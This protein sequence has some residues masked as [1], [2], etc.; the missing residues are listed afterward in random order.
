MAALALREHHARGQIKR[1]KQRGGAVTNCCQK[2]E[3]GEERAMTNDNVAIIGAGPYGLSI[4]AH[5]RAR[6]IEFRIFGRPMDTWL[7][8]M[9][10]SMRLKSE[11]FASSLY[12]PDSEFT[13]GAY[14]QHEGLPY[15]DLGLPVPLETFTSYGLAFQKRFVPQLENKTVVS[16]SRSS[17]GF[18]LRLEDGEVYCARR[19][20]VAVGLT[21]FDYT[22]PLLSTLPPELLTHSSAHHTVDHF[23]GR[24]VAVIGAGASALDLAA[25][26]HKAGAEVHVVARTSAIR[27]H[28]PPRKRSLWERIRRP[29][30]GLAHGWKLVFCTKAPLAFR[31]LPERFRLEFVRRVLGPAPGWFIKQEVVGKVPFHLGVNLTA[32]QVRNSRVHLELKNQAGERQ[33]LVADHVIAATGYRVDLRRLTF[34]SSELQSAI[35]AVEQTPILSSNFESSVPG[36]Y[37]VGIAAANSFGPLLRFAFGARFAA[38][39]LTKHLARA[40]SRAAVAVKQHEMRIEEADGTAARCGLS[41][42]R[43]SGRSGTPGADREAGYQQVSKNVSFPG[44]VDR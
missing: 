11:G 28:D 18:Q 36:L 26:L 34:M 15:A 20:I 29:N 8:R 19:V 30:T 17:G 41:V 31:L 4:A 21:H 35:D 10:T 25:V 5:L 13:L 7:T 43:L 22:P 9:P 3:N 23:Q 24:A 14:C 2:N 42:A 33:L 44:R 32:A 12:D 37:F 1:G 27:F 40:D 6:G 16:L 39:R 38:T